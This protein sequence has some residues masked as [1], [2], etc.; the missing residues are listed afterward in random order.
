MQ[1]NIENTKIETLKESKNLGIYS[2]EPLPTG[3]GA[4]LGNSLRRI[5]LTSLKGAAVTQIKINGANHQFTTLPGIKEDIVEMT[6]NL[7]KLKFKLHGDETV[8]ATIKKKG[9]GAV[10]GA[11]ITVSSEAEVMNKDQHIATLANNKAEIN[12]ELVIESGTGYSPMEERQTSKIGVIVLDSLFSPIL[13]S[14]YEIEPTRFGRKADLD[15]LILTVETDGSIS[16]KNAIKESAE[17]LRSY[18]EHILKWEAPSEAEEEPKENK[19]K[20]TE[21]ISIDELPLQTRT[22]NALKKHGIESLQ[23]LAKKSDEEISDIKNLGEKS[24]TEIKKLLEKEGY[25]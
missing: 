3:F 2:I 10:T 12:M 20:H 6:L 25:R 14:T 21:T 23:Q 22:V 9:P 11:D 1:V 16:P 5:L 7:K 4:T 17:I 8:I 13:R 15:K 18:Y 24:L 19:V